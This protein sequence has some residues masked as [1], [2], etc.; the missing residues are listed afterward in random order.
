MSTRMP[1][2]T[3]PPRLHQSDSSQHEAIK[4]DESRGGSTVDAVAI[5]RLGFLIRQSVVE[6]LSLLIRILP[7]LSAPRAPTCSPSWPA[8]QTHVFQA[9]P[10]RS[11]LRVDSDLVVESILFQLFG[12]I[13][14]R[15]SNRAPSKPG[16][17]KRLERPIQLDMPSCPDLGAGCFHDTRCEQI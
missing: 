6:D 10:L 4:E 7:P 9:I 15:V 13:E 3:M 14:K 17:S 5:R 16:K 1:R 12:R 2:P 8:H 11:A